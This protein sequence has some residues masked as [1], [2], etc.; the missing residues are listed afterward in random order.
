[1]EL[2]EMK[3]MTV[4]DKRWVEVGSRD[5]KLVED[6]WKVYKGSDNEIEVH[7]QAKIFRAVQELNETK[8]L[9]DLDSENKTLSKIYK[10]GG[11]EAKE[12]SFKYEFEFDD[13]EV[14]F[15]HENKRSRAYVYDK[16]R[17]V[18][19]FMKDGAIEM[20]DV[21]HLEQLIMHETRVQRLFKF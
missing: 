15:I 5:K 19:E 12:G 14:L 11:G 21:K 10:I 2:T 4:K 17:V 7:Y 18:H 3:K 16:E 6:F 20:L 8:K 13:V 1:M 9:T